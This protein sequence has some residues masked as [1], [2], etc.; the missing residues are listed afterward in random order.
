MRDDLPQINQ[1][2]SGNCRIQTQG[3]LAPNLA[4]T[5]SLAAEGRGFLPGPAPPSIREM[6]AGG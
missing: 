6:I 5:G 3:L 2:E 4:L 1:L